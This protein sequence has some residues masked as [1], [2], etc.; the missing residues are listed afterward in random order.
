MSKNDTKITKEKIISEM[1]PYEI[2]MLRHAY[3]R[4]QSPE[5]E[6]ADI[7]AF[8]ETFCIHAR[9]LIDFFWDRKPK[10]KNHAIARHFISGPYDPF[11]GVSPKP[12]RLYAKLND[13]IVHLSYSRTDVME[14]KIGPKERL[15]LNN[16]I[17]KEIENF[18]SHIDASYQQLWKRRGE[19]LT[20]QRHNT[21]L[22]PFGATGPIGP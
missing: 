18:G 21:T 12:N 16:L 4:S 6:Q 1:L 22:G 11:G 15:E 3:Q 19:F 20:L 14:E 17:E 2:D 8:I 13:Q 10:K 5:F 7:N 9:S